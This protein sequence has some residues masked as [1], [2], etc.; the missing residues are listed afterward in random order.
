MGM[1][2]LVGAGPGHP[3]LLTARAIQVLRAADIVVYDRLLS[4]RALGF[5]PSAA[6]FIYVGKESGNHAMAQEQINLLLVRFARQGKVVVRLKGGDP[7][8]FGRGS[9]EADACQAEGVPFEVVPGVTSAVAASAFAG[10][11]VTHRGTSSGFTVVTGHL[12]TSAANA[13]IGSDYDRHGPD[14]EVAGEG[15]VTGPGADVAG[16]CTA[17]GRDV[18]VVGECM[19]I[20]PDAEVDGQD[21]G[22]HT[23]T[24][25][26]LMGMSH[27]ET[28]TQKLVASGHSAQ[29]PVALVR[30]GSRALQETLV[31]TLGDISQRAKDVRF[32]SPAVIIVGDVVLLRNRIKWYEHT[33]LM[34][35]RVL[36]AA[37]TKDEGRQMAAKLETLGAETLD[38]AVEQGTWT[39][40]LAV[41]QILTPKL[42]E[43]VRTKPALVFTHV[44]AVHQFF[45]TVDA[46][47]V[48]PRSLGQFQF[49]GTTADVL[50][51]LAHWH[52]VPDFVMPDTGMPDTG[53]P[54]T[55]MP[56]T[57]MPDTAVLNCAKPSV[58]VPDDAPPHPFSSNESDAP[59][60]V[61]ADVLHFD[62]AY[63]NGASQFCR[64]TV[65]TQQLSAM[66]DAIDSDFDLCWAT[67]S[68]ALDFV[69]ALQ[70]RANG[71][72]LGNIPIQMGGDLSDVQDILATDNTSGRRRHTDTR[73]ATGYAVRGDDEGVRQTARGVV[74]RR[75]EWN[76]DEG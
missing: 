50:N 44:Q 10:I 29:T 30:W 21:F 45:Q 67:T 63:L 46:L 65:D 28:I 25:V 2:Y 59:I 36:I 76:C 35:R 9:E 17:T 15:T 22:T 19:A 40:A 60:R 55:G 33:P 64:I 54:D 27:L 6:D 20:G 49:G 4:P 52:I 16:K 75:I 72:R 47:R 57:G 8:V 43:S 18:E 32:R 26:I 31:G 7:F 11:P 5:A 62:G 42:T 71:Y 39:N 56:D 69:R 23:Q 12:G 53:M 38:I 66:W 14:A 48:D 34:G 37:D 73:A 24:L 51:A 3:G 70:E 13:A 68:E 58:A 41:Q 61:N 1:V 74:T